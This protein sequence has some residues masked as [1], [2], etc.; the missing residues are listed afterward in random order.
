MQD[1]GCSA[2]VANPFKDGD[3][4]LITVEW[5]GKNCEK[6]HVMK[7]VKTE[8]ALHLWQIHSRMEIFMR[9]QWS[10]WGKTVRRLV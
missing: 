3:V 8:D 4:Y 7:E 1:R 10:G 9:L 6:T 5:L 2:F